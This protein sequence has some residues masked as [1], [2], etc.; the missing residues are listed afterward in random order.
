[1]KKLGTLLALASLGL[2]AGAALAAGGTTVATG[3]TSLGTILVGPNGHTL[4]MFSRDTKTKSNC[5]GECATNWPPLTTHGKP[6]A[7]AGAK[8]A[9]LGTISRGGGVEQV[10][11]DGH[12]LYYYI[13]DTAKGQTSGQGTDVDGGWWY[14]LSPSGSVIKKGSSKSGGG[15]SGW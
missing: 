1:M 9:E 12:P 2:G 8:A 14:V 6:K 10:T 11:Y 3:K 4:Y 5:S 7:V 13:A 15:G